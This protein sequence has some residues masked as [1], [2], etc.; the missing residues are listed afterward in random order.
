VAI[1]LRFFTPHGSR[2]LLYL[3]ILFILSG[4]ML[5]SIGFLAEVIVSLREEIEAL[6]ARK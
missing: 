5:F 4:L 1:Y 6:R 2:T 3:V